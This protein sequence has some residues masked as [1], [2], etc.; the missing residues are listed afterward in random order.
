MNTPNL[1]LFI[2]HER[3]HFTSSLLPEGTTFSC[4]SQESSLKSLRKNKASGN[5][6]EARQDPGRF[7]NSPVRRGLALGQPGPGSGILWILYG[8]ISAPPTAALQ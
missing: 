5:T 6:Q 2:G 3:E 4:D 8:L 7:C 1:S